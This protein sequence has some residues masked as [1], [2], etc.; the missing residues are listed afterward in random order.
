MLRTAMAGSILTVLALGA[1]AGET[2]PKAYDIT[3]PAIPAI[4]EH[5]ISVPAVPPVKIHYER[6]AAEEESSEPNVTSPGLERGISFGK[7]TPPDWSKKEQSASK[8]AAE[9]GEVNGGQVSLYLRGGLMEPDA[10]AAALEAAGFSVLG[11]F[12]VDKKAEML[13]IIFTDDALQKAAAKPGRGFAASLRVLVDKNGKQ[14]SI[15]NPL[16]VSK[17]FLQDDYDAAAAEATLAKLRGAFTGLKNSD[18][19]FK[20]EQLPTFQFMETMPYYQDRIEVGTGDT[21][22]LLEKARASK[23]LA[24]EQSLPNGSVLV[25]VK[26]GSHTSEFVKKIGSRNAGLLPYPVLIENGKALM[27][28]PKYYIAVMYPQLS[29]SN[30]MAIAAVPGAISKACDN[31]FR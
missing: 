4:P 14:I 1:W 22:A 20:F 13:S 3:I 28:E 26:L 8:S 25:G 27:L 5:N 2:S 29:M 7:R 6:S 17:A 15:M 21:A 19:H 12:P 9:V 31:I 18:D 30:F 11:R 10:V 23:Q 16:Y 24:F